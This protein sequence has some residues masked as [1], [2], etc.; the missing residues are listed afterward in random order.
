MTSSRIDK[1]FK[2]IVECRTFNQS[3]FITKAL[4]GFVCQETDF[5]FICAIIDDASTDGEQSV[6]NDYYYQ[7]F[8]IDN[9]KDCFKEDTEFAYVKYG[10]HKTNHNCYFLILLLKEN[11]YSISKS[12]APYI[13]FFISDADFYAFCEGDDYWTDSTKLQRQI[14]FLDGHFDYVAV[15]ENGVVHNLINNTE[16]LFS[17]EKE[18]D[19]T[20]REMIVKRRFPTA[21]VVFRYECYNRMLNDARYL[22]DTMRWCLLC[23]YGKF[24]YLENVS[25]VYNRGMQ[26]VTENTPKLQWAIRNEMWDLELMRLFS[27]KYVEKEVLVQDIYSHFLYVY[28]HTDDKQIRQEAY[29]KMREYRSLWR[30]VKDILQRRLTTIIKRVIN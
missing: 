20:I 29:A 6:I 27:P 14:T 5:P 18:R 2:L 21:S 19:L 16:S 10:R 24:R 26:G 3:G 17:E 4:D 13:K 30:C 15:A 28:L 25:S 12:I 9:S 1:R 11:H 22:Y 8:N 23:T 7:N